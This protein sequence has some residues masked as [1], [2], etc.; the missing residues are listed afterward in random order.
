MFFSNV[1]IAGKYNYLDEK[2]TVAY[3][4]LAETDIKALPEGSYPLLGDQ[5][6][7]NVQEYTTEPA[8]QRFF[9]SHRLYF[10][11]QFMVT[12]EEMF[13]VCKTEGLV[14]REEIPAND[15]YFYEE[16]DMSGEVYLREGDLIVVAPEDAHKPRC[17]AGQPAAV[18][19]VVV[20]VAI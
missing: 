18:K 6:I 17:A 15:L 14:L 16:P 13:G 3:K 20:K 1:S 10:D 5:V 7:A 19:K 12:G 8:E 11:I 2:F 4:W 9:E